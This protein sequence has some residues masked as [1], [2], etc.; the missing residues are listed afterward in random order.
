MSNQNA[1]M[2]MGGHELKGYPPRPLNICERPGTEY[3]VCKNIGHMIEKGDAILVTNSIYRG[4]RKVLVV[5][6][7]WMLVRTWRWY[8]TF[9]LWFWG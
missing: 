3:I 4:P 2:T 7:G 9:W 5:H 6:Q 1:Q 8:D